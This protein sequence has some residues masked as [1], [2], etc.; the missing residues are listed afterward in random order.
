M[1]YSVQEGRMKENFKKKDA[2]PGKNCR[3]LT[4]ASPRYKEKSGIGR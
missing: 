4:I 2:Y 3:F 1:V